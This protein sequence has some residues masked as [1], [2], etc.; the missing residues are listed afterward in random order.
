MQQRLRDPVQRQLHV[1]GDVGRV[2]RP[3]PAI[4]FSTAPEMCCRRATTAGSMRRMA[5]RS[6]NSATPAM[7]MSCAAATRP[8]M[9]RVGLRGHRVQVDDPDSRAPTAPRRG[10]S[11]RS[12]R[13]M[14]GS[15]VSR[16]GH[17]GPSSSVGR[18]RRRWCRCT[19]TTRSAA[20]SA[21]EQIRAGQ[22]PGA[23][24]GRRRSR[25]RPVGENTRSRRSRG[26]AELGRDHPRIGPGADHRA[27]RAPPMPGRAVRVR[28]PGRPRRP[29]GR[30]RRV[31]CRGDLLGG[32]G[33]G[34]EQ[35]VQPG[36]TAPAVLAPRANARATCPPISASPTTIESSPDGD[37]EQ[38]RGDGRAD[39]HLQQ[40]ARPRPGHTRRRRRRRS[41]RRSR[42]GSGSASSV[43]LQP[44][45]GGQ[46]HP[47]GH[48][49]VR[50]GAGPGR[51]R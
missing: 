17:G 43:D 8:E 40:L 9:R 13:S 22:R 4:S 3:E 7:T 23:C 30:R 12:A 33:G 18:A 6:S 49:A 10:T 39:P 28:C 31:R 34:L 14:T 24:A 35:Q 50:R 44:V 38:V 21:A 16:R 26:P 48:R 2:L 29:S 47:A 32:A 36:A 1:G 25:S 20:A 42:R 15:G 46:Q 5:S 41:P 19:T 51:H 45:A 27:A 11:A 37:G